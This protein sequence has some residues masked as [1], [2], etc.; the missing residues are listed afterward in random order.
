[1]FIPTFSDFL[2]KKLLKHNLQII[3]GRFKK[4]GL[5]TPEQQVTIA[6]ML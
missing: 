2:S 4:V 5:Q 3:T 6:S 1:M